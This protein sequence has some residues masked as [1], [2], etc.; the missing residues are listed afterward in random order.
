MLTWSIQHGIAIGYYLTFVFGGFVT[1][2]NRECRAGFRP[3]VMSPPGVRSTWVKRSYDFLGTLFSILLINFASAPFIILTFTDSTETWSRLGWYGCWI[4]GSGVVFFNAGGS[5]YLQNL[6]KK[7]AR[8]VDVK[9][10][11]ALSP[12]VGTPLEAGVELKRQIYEAFPA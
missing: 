8:I 1:Y 12:P 3:L 4:V 9:K 7:Q 5:K 10:P 2:I 6:Q 11:R